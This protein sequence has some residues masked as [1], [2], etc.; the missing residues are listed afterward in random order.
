VR[1]LGRVQ[2]GTLR[3][4]DAATLLGGQLSPG[5]T[6]GAAVPAEGE[7]LQHR[8]AGRRPIARLSRRR[9]RG[10]WPWCVR[11]IPTRRPHAS[12][13]RWRPGSG[14]GRANTVRIGSGASARGK[15][16]AG[17]DRARHA[18]RPHVRRAGDSD[19]SGELTAVQTAQRGR[20]RHPSRS[21][22]EEAAPGWGS[23]TRRARMPG[24]RR[25][26]RITISGLRARLSRPRIFTCRCRAP[27]GLDQVFR[28]ETTRTVSND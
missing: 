18:I 3:L 28:L 2:A 10:S 11:N 17:R 27:Y 24:S 21:A 13:R 8:S 6:V 4:R 7:E 15:R 25:I 26:R 23:A 19:H 22:R 16:A 1:A 20:A 12:V 5:E 9:G 14:A